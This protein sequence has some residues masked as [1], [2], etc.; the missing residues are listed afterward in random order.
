M[1]NVEKSK[2][3]TLKVSDNVIS[4]IVK[5]AV[6]EIDGVA[7]LN[8]NDVSFRQLFIKSGKSEAIKIK[9][10]GDVV[11]ISMSIIVKAGTKVKILAE[12]IQERVKADVQNMTGITVSK[13]NILIAGI[14]FDN[15][16]NKN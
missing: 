3:G 15:I 13:V 4:T 1:E 12:H 11:E 7:G 9:L 5:L 2:K 16:N 10:M 6:C 14:V 8:E